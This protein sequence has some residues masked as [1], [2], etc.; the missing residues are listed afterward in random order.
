MSSTASQRV[1]IGD[2]LLRRLEEAG[3]RQ[4]FGVSGDF[5]LPL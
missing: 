5:N 1:K 3:V 2:F 4:I